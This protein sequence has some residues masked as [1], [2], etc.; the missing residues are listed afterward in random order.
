MN[1]K[2]V[3]FDLRHLPDAKLAAARVAGLPA[4][5]R[6]MLALQRKVEGDDERND[7]LYRQAIVLAPREEMTRLNKTAAVTPRIKMD[8]CWIEDDSQSLDMVLKSNALGSGTREVLYWPGDLTFGR[9]LP[10]LVE[11]E[12]PVGGALAAAGDAEGLALLPVEVLEQHRGLSPADLLEALDG[13]GKVERVEPE[14]VALRL[15]EPE[16]VRRAEAALLVSLRKPV[17]GVVAKY[18]R[19]V[20]LAISRQL[21]K[22]PVSPSVIT[23]LA[24]VVGIVCG[25]VAAGGTYWTL[26]LGALLFQVN[27]ILDGVDGEIARAKLLESNTGQWLDT[28]TDDLSNVAFFAGASVGC[29]RYYDSQLYLVVGVAIIVSFL[30]DIGLQYHHLLTTQGTGDLSKYTMP[31]ED[32][33]N[34]EGETKSQQAGRFSLMAKIFQNIRCVVRRD[35]HA[36]I[37]VL[38]CIIGQMRI[39]MFFILLGAVVV[40]YAIVTYRYVLPYLQRRKERAAP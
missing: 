23:V 31:W 3:I 17:D 27:S 29:W 18:D 36:F 19:Y 39:M 21:M 16:D 25:I 28:I 10:Q 11:G 1:N 32:Q 34:T 22:L 12:A 24:G 5:D 38:W 14:E 20:S 2:T 7:P 8:L 30:L 35:A 26:L 4:L 37:S 13:E 9:L 15:R 6:T 33:P 40:L